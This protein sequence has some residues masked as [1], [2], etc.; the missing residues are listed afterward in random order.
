MNGA[1]IFK[2]YPLA[3]VVIL[4]LFLFFL[5]PASQVFLVM[6]A[7]ILF[8]ILVDG[9]AEL[10]TLRL[11]MSQTVARALVIFLL[12][13]LVTAF[14]MLAGPQFSD[15]ISQLTTQL[16]RAIERLNEVIKEQPWGKFLKDIEIVES[17]KPSTGQILAD[18][19]GV[20][21]SV[22]ETITNV[23]VVFFIGLYL[24]VQPEI[25]VRGVMHLV[26][27]QNRERAC[28]VVQ[29]LGHALRWWMV[30]RFSSMAVVGLLTTVALELIGLPLALV[31]GVIAGLFSFVP[32]IGPITSVVPAM[33]IGLMQSPLMAL[34]VLIVYSVV[35][36]IEGH[37]LTPLIQK[38]A[39]S[40]PPAVLLS[41]QFFMAIFYGLFGVLLATPLAVCIIVLVQMLYV[42]DVLKDEVKVLGE[43]G[44]PA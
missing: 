20:F 18:L 34:I 29:A 22:V 32:Y 16:P 39:V 40:M 41:S 43:H 27:K 21:S 17:L 5:W 35:Q 12:L 19:S 36:F 6:F 33:L 24:A 42:Q 3:V 7:A 25:Y 23:V 44:P 38:R 28:E 15:Q 31:L 14:F 8:A 37:F 11:T 2:V 10:L 26:P 9:L 13:T 4:G 1:K 30:G